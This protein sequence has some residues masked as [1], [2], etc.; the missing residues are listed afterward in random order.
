[1]QAKKKKKGK[2]TCAKKGELFLSLSPLALI[3][4]EKRRK[5]RKL[6]LSKHVAKLGN[7]CVRLCIQKSHALAPP[8][9]SKAIA[10]QSPDDDG[11][12]S[13]LF[14]KKVSHYIQAG[15][16]AISGG[17]SSV[18]LPP[19]PNST[20]DGRIPAH[21]LPPNVTFFYNRKEGR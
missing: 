18:A 5:R 9:P 17:A 6:K 14:V 15:G 21:F 1:M 20:T 16:K 8:Q 13:S 7:W 2:R 11:G 12:G 10:I 4:G 3:N 19:P